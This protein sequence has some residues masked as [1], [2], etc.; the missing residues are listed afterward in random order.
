[1]A[2]HTFILVGILMLPSSDD[3]LM[4]GMVQEG[5][6]PEL[7]ASPVVC[8]QGSYLTQMI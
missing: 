1:M 4:S 3:N 5:D 2:A 6:N 8:L 7:A